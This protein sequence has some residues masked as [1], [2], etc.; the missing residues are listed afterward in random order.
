MDEA[1]VKAALDR[2]DAATTQAATNIAALATTDQ[3]I[4][5]EFDT[6]NKALAGALAGGQGVTQA[7]VDQASALAG[8]SQAVSD[9]LAAMVPALTAIASKGVTNPVPL[10]IPPAP[11]AVQPNA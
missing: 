2:I 3:A 5:N 4:S 1:L 10:P 6:L 7:L 11:P 8:K 9:S